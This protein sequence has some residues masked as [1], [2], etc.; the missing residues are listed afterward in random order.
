MTD[1]THGVEQASGW[2]QQHVAGAR[3]PFRFELIA[4]GHSNLTYRVTGADGTRYVLRRPPLGHVL[5]S[6]HDV[7]REHRILAALQQTAVPVPPVLGYCIDADI[8]G[9]PFFVMGFV[10]GAI[11]RTADD[12][13]ALEPAA[14]RRASASLVE[15]LAAI[16]AVDLPASGL[17]G[18]ARHEGYVAR[19]LK[20]WYEQWN[21][22]KTRELPAVDRAFELLSAR[23]P[24]QGPATL[25]HADFRLDN[26]IVTSSGNVAAVLDWELCTLGDP[27]ADLGLLCIYWAGPGDEA[28]VWST[29][30]TTAEGFLDRG[31]IVTR[32][33]QISGRD[34]SQLGFYVAFAQWKVACVLEGVYARYLRGALGA[35]DVEEFAPFKHQVEVAAASA[36]SALERM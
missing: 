32:Y 20:R 8:I 6:A 21:A 26:C 1:P 12:A 18:L 22:Q 15:T 3:G 11:V 9:A 14:R 7:G 34:L 25:V 27:L 19:Q 16:H 33:G 2:L 28:P 30:G 31:D 5:A 10:D 35:R 36:A 17:D 29:G 13:T 24:E 4:G 23:I